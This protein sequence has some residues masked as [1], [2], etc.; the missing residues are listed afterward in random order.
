M[1]KYTLPILFALL[2]TPLALQLTPLEIL[3][4]K[5]F[6]TFVAK[7]EP[8]GNFVILDI[9]EE[10]IEK[11]GVGLCRVSGIEIQIDLLEAG[12]F[13]QAWAFTFPQPDRMGGDIAFSEALSYGP[14]VLAMF[15][16][17]NKSYPPTVG[18]TVIL[19]EDTEV[20]IKPEALY[21]I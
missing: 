14:S 8:T 5:L 12:S 7:Q 4:L 20:V 10:D 21:K 13:G 3:K 2:I 15:E 18:G 6:D 11:E 17:D 1:K 16:N 19:G 9:N